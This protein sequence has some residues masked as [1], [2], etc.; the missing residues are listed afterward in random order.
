MHTM[1]AAL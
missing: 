1:H